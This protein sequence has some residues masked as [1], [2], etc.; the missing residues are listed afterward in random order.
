M[1]HSRLTVTGAW[2]KAG[3]ASCVRVQGATKND[4]FLFD[5]GYMD[6]TTTNAKVW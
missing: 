6:S 1:E 3:I 5:C 2:T 4:D